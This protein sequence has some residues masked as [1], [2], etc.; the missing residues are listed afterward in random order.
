MTFLAF[1]I[2]A[3]GAPNHCL[4]ATHLEGNGG[5]SVYD[6][7]T[8]LLY[9]PHWEDIGESLTMDQ[10]EVAKTQCADSSSGRVVTIDKEFG[11][12]CAYEA[13][14]MRAEYNQ[15]RLDIE[16]EIKSK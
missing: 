5:S 4:K 7:C 3:T 6:S 14:W 9:T 11:L 1:I 10:W 8:G 15:L 2:L 13:K 16:N 12:V